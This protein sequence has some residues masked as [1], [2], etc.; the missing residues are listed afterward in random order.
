MVFLIPHVHLTLVMATQLAGGVAL[1]WNLVFLCASGLGVG[2]EVGL[3]VAVRGRV[4]KGIAQ[5]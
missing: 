2:L 4:L 5:I 3:A 1:V